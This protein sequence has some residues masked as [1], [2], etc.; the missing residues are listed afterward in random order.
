M[1]AGR[2]EGAGI[3]RPGNLVLRSSEV[4]K[5][6]S[7]EVTVKPE[8]YTISQSEINRSI[9]TKKANGG[10]MKIKIG[11]M[12]FLKCDD[13][14]ITIKGINPINKYN[15]TIFGIDS[16]GHDVSFKESDIKRKVKI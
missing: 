1:N 2:L 7:S 5:L 16:L 12:V 13:R 11:K 15:P 6:R 14:I 4:P 9:R 8:I 3:T 10:K